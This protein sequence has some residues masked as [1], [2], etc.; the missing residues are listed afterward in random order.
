MKHTLVSLF[1]PLFCTTFLCSAD[2]A[3]LR[4]PAREGIEAIYDLD[5]GKAQKIFDQL[6]NDYPE[7]PV[8]YGMTA[9]RAWHELLFASRNLAIYK[10]GMPTPFDSSE[11]KSKRSVLLKDKETS[12]VEANEKLKKVCD[13]ILKEDSKNALALYFK[14]VS[15]E[16]LSTKALTLDGKWQLARKY[17]EDAGDLHQDAL[18]YNP[19]LIDAKTSTA[20]P[21]Y[22]VGSLPWYERWPALLL[23]MK[24]NRDRAI[25]KLQEVIEKGIY[26]S[27]DARVV[28]ALLELEYGDRQRAISLFKSVQV[29]HPRSF[30]CDI[31]LG[32]A[33]EEAKDWMSAI[34]V[35]RDLL[36]DI[37]SKAPGIQPGEI[38]FRIAKDY[39][40]L[41]DNSLALEQFQNA[42]REKQGDAETKPLA[43]YEMGHIYEDRKDKEL[44]KDCYRKAVEYAGS[45]TLITVEID[46][47]K[48]KLR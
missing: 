2:D 48:K 30:M 7:N 45:S 43:Y 22:V 46:D 18:K 19:N 25:K 15:Y 38:Y 16:N 27:T 29:K 31:S 17:A 37:S 11:L 40:K 32:V 33:Y 39:V 6:K 3:L 12:F 9:I 14:G 36:R 4:G 13:E 8:G 35:Y 44:A 26:R 42:V 28:L 1:L 23:G 41:H 5:Y 47:A 20:V 21:E 34:K 10:Y 24:G